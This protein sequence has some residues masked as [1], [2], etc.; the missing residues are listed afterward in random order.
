MTSLLR[1]NII[2]YKPSSDD[3]IQSFYHA[4][5][6]D[7]SLRDK[8]KKEDILANPDYASQFQWTPI[9]LRDSPQDA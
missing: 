9:Q 2:S 6:M 4:V 3:D 7:L 8:H 5:T 1:K